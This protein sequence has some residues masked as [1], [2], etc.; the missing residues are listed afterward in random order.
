[1][2]GLKLLQSVCNTSGE[3]LGRSEVVGRLGENSADEACY[4]IIGG[5]SMYLGKERTRLYAIVEN[6]VEV[7]CATFSGVQLQ[8]GRVV[9]RKLN[10]LLQMLEASVGCLGCMLLLT[11]EAI[12]YPKE[13]LARKAASGVCISIR[14][15]WL[16][17]LNFFTKVRSLAVRRRRPR[18]AL[19]A[20]K[21][22]VVLPSLLF[23]RVSRGT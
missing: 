1:M 4:A 16:E 9:R 2:A 18:S 11:L 12:A 22:F 5:S 17:R 10:T 13:T 6:A 20:S 8:R 15:G 3:A 19:H 21:Y 7:V 14:R 23:R